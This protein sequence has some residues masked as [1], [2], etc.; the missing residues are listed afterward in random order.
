MILTWKEIFEEKKSLLFV[1]LVGTDDLIGSAVTGA[2][3]V[4]LLASRWAWCQSRS[5]PSN[6]MP[7][8]SGG[9]ATLKYLQGDAMTGS[10][11]CLGPG[12]EPYP[13]YVTSFS[14][15]RFQ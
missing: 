10:T 12:G 8:D 9:V 4:L 11:R 14:W 6:L 13:S 5:E 1:G 3:L 7:C 2:V 15:R